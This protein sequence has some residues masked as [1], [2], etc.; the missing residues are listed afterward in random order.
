MIL[1]NAV[2]QQRHWN[3]NET[4]KSNIRP[5]R[6]PPG[7]WIICWKIP[8]ENPIVIYNAMVIVHSVPSLKTWESLFQTLKLSG[9]KKLY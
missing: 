4:E 2:L 5:Q 9:Y 1:Y 7:S 6:R 8:W 3:K